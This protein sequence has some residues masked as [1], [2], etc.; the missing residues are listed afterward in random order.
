MHYPECRPSTNPKPG[1]LIEL[2]EGVRLIAGLVGVKRDEI[3]IGQ[4]VKVEFQT[5]DDG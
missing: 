3:R 2:D 4:R 1:R 5:F